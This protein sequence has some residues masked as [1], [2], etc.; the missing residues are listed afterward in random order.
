MVSRDWLLDENPATRM[1]AR[2]GQGYRVARMLAH[3]P[4]AM[5]GAAIILGLLLV[6]A[7]A[8]WLAPYSPF[9]GVLADRLF[10]SGG[11]SSGR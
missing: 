1:Q 5:V 6:A 2:L 8:P 10:G 3:N 11:D 7:F 9:E 4:L